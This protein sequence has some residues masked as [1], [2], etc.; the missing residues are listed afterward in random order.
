MPITTLEP[1]MKPVDHLVVFRWKPTASPSEKDAAA[2]AIANLIGQIEGITA[3][4]GG[5]QTSNEPPGK[6][7]DFGFRMT[8]SGVAARD[9]YVSHPKH[10]E[11]VK[12][13]IAPILDAAVVFDIQH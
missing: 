7:W 4:V 3:Y 10:V 11:A 12:T 6:G 5:P 13:Y 2:E 9:A 8:F 1:H